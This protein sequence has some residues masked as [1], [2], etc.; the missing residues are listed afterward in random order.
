M[1]PQGQETIKRT[2]PLERIGLYSELDGIIFLLAS[3]AS[4][5]ITGECIFIDG[6]YVVNSI[7]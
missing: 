7:T 2:I 6:G 4:T 5:Y 1:S 3:N